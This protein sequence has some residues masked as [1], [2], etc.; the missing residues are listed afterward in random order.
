MSDSDGGPSTPKKT[1]AI[2]NEL[3]TI[4]K[5]RTNRKLFRQEWLTKDEFKHWLEEV[6]RD[7]L[8]AKC[9]VCN[10]ILTSG[11]SELDKHRNG[12]KHIINCKGLKGTSKIL[13]MFS[14][15]QEP[16]IKN[17][18]VKMAEIK[19]AAFFAEHNLAF[20]LID[21]LTPLLKEIFPDSK[22]CSKLELHR[23]KCTSIINKIIAPVETSDITDIILKNPFSVLVDESTDISSQKFLCLLVRF[24]HP[25]DGTIHTKLLELV[26]IDAR[27]CSAKSI[28]SEFKEV[29]IKKHIPLD[30]IIG[31]ACDGASVMVGKHNSFMT[32]ITEDSP[33]VI[34]MQCICHSS[35]IIASKATAQLPRSAE[36]LIRS[37]AT[38]VSGSAKRCAQLNEVQDYF[39]GQRKKMLKLAD[40]RWLAMH[41]CVFRLL[42]CWDSLT[43]Y[44]RIAIYEDKLKSAEY[45]Y[46]ELQNPFTKCYLLF[47]KFSLD[48]F[49]TFN[50]LFQ[51]RKV[52]IHQLVDLSLNLLKSICQNFIK[53][54]FITENIFMID[55]KNKENIIPL[56]EVFVGTECESLLLEQN[57][58][59]IIIFKEK[60]LN[61]FV[62]ASEEMVKRLPF[63]NPMYKEIKFIAPNI[64]LDLE[65]RQQFKD[66]PALKLKFKKYIDTNKIT[67]EWRQLP[68]QFNAQEIERLKSLSIP[69]MWH[70][71]S[72]IKNF[73]SETPIF[74]NISKLAKLVLALPHSNAE[75]ER[76]FSII[77]HVKT[78]SRNRIGDK[79]L[80]S[81]SVIRSSFNDKNQTCMTFKVEDK[82]IQLHNYQNL[83]EKK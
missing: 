52:I 24:V 26:S 63:N 2:R 4:E 31:V 59:Q 32:H 22:I 43:Q 3:S 12:K 42:E 53:P 51:S 65:T 41:Q 37:V 11:K 46:T 62:T 1:H 29:L 23:T 79:S 75:A 18:E 68:C 71:L 73:T 25:N 10:V 40:T 33:N 39:D 49:N 61:F 64:A 20:H 45:I 78:K 5:Q 77:N 66:L 17:N 57:E 38:Y 81:V 9:V 27:D 7:P 15:I 48:Y 60:C 19:I 44:F 14:D 30:N 35:A 34:T 83:Y 69:E 6:P 55:F 74:T 67:E 80:N 47:L 58:D 76:V 70:E 13:T 21:H 82:H 54:K 28:Y 56:S 36:Q 16:K 8:K 72:M 50:A